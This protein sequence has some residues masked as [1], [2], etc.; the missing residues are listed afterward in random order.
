[1]AI[2]RVRAATALYI[3]FSAP[4]S[5][6]SA[7]IAA[8]KTPIVS[9]KL[10][11]HRGLLGE[12]FRL[13]HDLHLELRIGGQRVLELLERLRR[14]ELRIDR[15]KRVA[16]MVGRLEHGGIGPDFRF[17]RAA[18]AGEDADD[19]PLVLADADFL[20]HVQPG[21]RPRRAGADDDFVAARFETCGPG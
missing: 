21:E 12:E 19:F 20:A 3:V 10:R 4:N 13:A 8:M 17:R 16:A 7:I 5:A 9:M 1:M 11:Q 14:G 2:S 6:P 15:L 18:A